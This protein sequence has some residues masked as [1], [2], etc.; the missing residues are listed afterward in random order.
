MS[1][2][3]SEANIQHLVRP[4][5][6]LG[7]VDIDGGSLLLHGHVGVQK[8]LLVGRVHSELA[9]QPDKLK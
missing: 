8:R 3:Q 5:P 2:D 1:V 4:Q 6:G 7:E 9:R